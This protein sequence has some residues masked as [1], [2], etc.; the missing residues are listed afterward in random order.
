MASSKRRLKAKAAKASRKA[1]KQDGYDR[2][3]ESVNERTAYGK[4]SLARR[5]GEPMKAREFMPW[6]YKDVTSRAAY[7]PATQ[8]VVDHRDLESLVMSRLGM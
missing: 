3:K 7:A 2:P 6:W 4:R 8:R 1:A 5:R